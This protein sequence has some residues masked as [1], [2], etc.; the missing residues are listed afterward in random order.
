MR[1]ALVVTEVSVPMGLV[2]TMVD[3]ARTEQA[4]WTGVVGA[5][6]K[7]KPVKPV[8]EAEVEAVAAPTPAHFPMSMDMESMAAEVGMV[9]E[10]G[11]EDKADKVAEVQLVSFWSVVPAASLP[12]VSKEAAAA[13]AVTEAAAAL[14]VIQRPV[15]FAACPARSVSVSPP[16]VAGVVDMAATEAWEAEVAEDCPTVS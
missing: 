6:W 8:L 14:A 7:G 12:A 9:V 3:G 2:D 13:L 16:T 5:A 4:F 1:A 11:M 15:A 10:A